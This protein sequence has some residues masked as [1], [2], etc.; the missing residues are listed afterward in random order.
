MNPIHHVGTGKLSPPFQ[1]KYG[2]GEEVA[3]LARLTI[4]G[5]CFSNF[6]RAWFGESVVHVILRFI[7][8]FEKGKFNMCIGGVGPNEKFAKED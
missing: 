4:A 2:K 8:S 7:W 6:V 1:R 3:I 5:S